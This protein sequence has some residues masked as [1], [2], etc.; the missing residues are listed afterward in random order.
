[1]RRVGLALLVVTMTACGTLSGPRTGAVSPPT[2][3]LALWQTFPADQNPR[4]IVLLSTDSPGQGFDTND[5]TIAALC[6]KFAL[7]TRLPAEIPTPAGLS[8]ADAYA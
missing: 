3:A 1:M 2:D 4:P 7:H 5:A 8:A 6:N